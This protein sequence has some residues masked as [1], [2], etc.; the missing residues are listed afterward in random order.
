MVANSEV[1]ANAPLQLVVCEF[2]IGDNKPG[3]VELDRLREA[4]GEG[5][6]VEF[7]GPDLRLTPAGTPES[8]LFQVVNSGRTVAASVWPSS[9]AVE[10][11]DYVHFG[12]F[13]DRLATVFSAMYGDS[14]RRCERIGLRY[15]DELHPSPAPRDASEWTRWVHSS[16]LALPNLTGKRVSALGGGL[17]VDLGDDYA[18]NFRYATA[19]GPVVQSANLWLRPRPSSAALMLDTDAFW[20]PSRPQTVDSHSISAV[21]DRLHGGVREL[22]DIVITEDSRDFFRARE[23]QL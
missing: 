23:P 4:L 20:Q 16:L 10:D 3:Y 18:V 2:R 5:A 8:M 21:L 13:K 15:V 1:F 14:P 19:H 12:A 7:S 17:T 9:F 22:F 6:S 11:G